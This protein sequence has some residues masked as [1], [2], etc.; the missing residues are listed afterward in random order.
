MRVFSSLEDSDEH[1]VVDTFQPKS[2][3]ISL[4]IEAHGG[5]C[6]SM[7][8]QVRRGVSKISQQ[9]YGVILPDPGGDVGSIDEHIEDAAQVRKHP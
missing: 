4:V 7:D 8:C 2:P 9:G 3:R 1:I 6:V 5:S